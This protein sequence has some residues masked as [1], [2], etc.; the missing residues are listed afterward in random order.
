[1]KN[2]QPTSLSTLYIG[3][4]T[5]LGIF[6]IGLLLF[7][8]FYLDYNK[9][10]TKEQYSKL[11]AKYSQSAVTL[12]QDRQRMAILDLIDL[13][14]YKYF[15]DFDYTSTLDSTSKQQLHDFIATRPNIYQLRVI[16][17]LGQ[18]RLR[19]EK[20]KTQE[21]F[22]ASQLQDKSNRN[23]FIGAQKIDDNGVFISHVNFNI[24]G[25]TA[26]LP[27][28]TTIRFLKPLINSKAQRIG[29]LALNIEL[30]DFFNAISKIVKN[31]GGSIAILNGHGNWILQNNEIHLK[32]IMPEYKGTSFALPENEFQQLC[33]SPVL[34]TDSGT[35][36]PNLI[37]SK[38]FQFNFPITCSDKFYCLYSYLPKEL[39]NERIQ[40]IKTS[41]Y[42]GF[43]IFLFIA[44]LVILQTKAT[45]KQIANKQTKL[46]LI[47]QQLDAQ[48]AEL[49]YTNK[50]IIESNRKLEEFS[51]ILSHNIR[52]P[53]SNIK[54]L[55]EMYGYLEN[56]QEKAE[57]IQQI[58]VLSHELDDILFKVNDVL[59]I[60]KDIKHSSALVHIPTT[61]NKCVEALESLIEEKEAKIYTTFDVIEL[62]YP[63]VYLDSIFTNLISNAIK[64]SHPAR[65]PIILVRSFKIGDTLNISVEDNGIG[66]DMANFAD[67]IFELNKAFNKREKTTGFGLFLLKTQVES[68]GGK[69]EVESAVG[70]G[71]IFKV[72]I[73]KTL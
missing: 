12:L 55:S 28:R 27:L 23:Y 42:S 53:L 63:Q 2:N 46:E 45:F 48:T 13:S 61:Y 60:K 44:L 29:Y 43:G 6:G 62:N 65:K 39:I 11:Y 33:E 15:Q 58:Q 31:E 18:E 7:F 35:L 59:K 34:E 41:F 19:I 70:Q 22:F 16:D 54:G 10:E 20:N 36:F 24:E 3:Y 49:A 67:Q 14:A 66:I 69:I 47:N 73:P 21:I 50:Q 37:S 8:Q 4:G 26:E 72:V 30:T 52:S 51:Q 38:A 17:T 56:E 32:H 25:D 5:I 57:I 1:M 64:Y 68:L 71:S 40:P 9:S